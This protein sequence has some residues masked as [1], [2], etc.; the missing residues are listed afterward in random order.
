MDNSWRLNDTK[1]VGL[2]NYL[3]NSI[4]KYSSITISNIKMFVNSLNSIDDI[5]NPGE[6]IEQFIFSFKNNL[7]NFYSEVKLIVK[8][9]KET[10]KKYLNNILNY[11]NYI[12]SENKKLKYILNKPRINNSQNI[13]KKFYNSFNRNKELGNSMKLS[14]S[15]NAMFNPKYNSEIYLDNKNIFL[16]DS[17]II[18]N[19]NNHDFLNYNKKEKEKNSLKKE[20]LRLKINMVK[21]YLFIIN[22]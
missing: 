12:T 8:N 3:S 20:N 18:N 9:L 6:E 21:I 16:S 14:L 5:L 17:S 10:R 19:I 4:Y 13:K 22:Y 11:F 15:E 7:T 1:Y 2:I